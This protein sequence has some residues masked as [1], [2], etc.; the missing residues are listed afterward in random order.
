MTLGIRAA[1]SW[2]AERKLEP[3]SKRWHVEVSLATLDGPVPI[4]YDDRVD[5]RFHI[6]VYSL[7]WGFYFCHGG[8]VS[9]IR[10]T[11][12]SFVH[13]RDDFRLFG[14]APSLTDIGTLLASLEKQHALQFRRRH[15]L[16]RTNIASAEPAIRRWVEAL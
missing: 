14:Q 9:W 3:P 5:T 6:D 10:T 4:N 12:V 11:D 1:A 8:K 13:G 7:E 2:L 15:A 16:V